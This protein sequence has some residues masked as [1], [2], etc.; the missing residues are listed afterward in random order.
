MPLGWCLGSKRGIANHRNAAS[1]AKSSAF[2]LGKASGAWQCN[3]HGSDGD[4]E[5]LT[6]TTP[7]AS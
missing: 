1:H 4:E 6:A 5:V 7:V 2:L 3:H